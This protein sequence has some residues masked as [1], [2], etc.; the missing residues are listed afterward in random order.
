MAGTVERAL[1][2]APGCRSLDELRQKLM[3]EGHTN[4]DAHLA[5]AS[6]R[7]SLKKLMQSN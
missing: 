7:G 4:V 3:K 1:Q 6:L 2:L 5:G